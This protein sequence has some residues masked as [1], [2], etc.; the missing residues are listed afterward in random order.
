MADIF[1]SPLFC[2]RGHRVL[3]RKS[4]CCCRGRVEIGRP[5]GADLS[6]QPNPGDLRIQIDFPL[7]SN[8]PTLITFQESWKSVIYTL[9][10]SVSLEVK[11]I[12]SVCLFYSYN[13]HFRQ[14]RC[15]IEGVN[16]KE[17]YM[18]IYS[19]ALKLSLLKLIMHLSETDLR[20]KSTK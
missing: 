6:I 16:A 9:T 10:L 8:F 19:I 20:N 14:Y 13:D 11:A 5:Q 3:L 12:G 18:L 4:E 15:I 17:S 1:L 7:L 2:P